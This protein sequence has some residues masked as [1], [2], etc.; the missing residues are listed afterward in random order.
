MLSPF[1]VFNT[2]TAAIS[3]NII[4][5]KPYKI[6]RI[7]EEMLTGISEEYLNMLANVVKMQIYEYFGI[8]CIL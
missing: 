8:L 2:E 4:R 6:S 7:Q 1:K 3:L 5:D